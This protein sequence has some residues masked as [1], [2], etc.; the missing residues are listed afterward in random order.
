MSASLPLKGIKVLDFSSLLPGPYATM[1][2]AP[3][4]LNNAHQNVEKALRQR[5]QVQE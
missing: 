5:S 4:S 3:S 2:R 1:I